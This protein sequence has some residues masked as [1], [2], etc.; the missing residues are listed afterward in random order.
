MSDAYSDIMLNILNKHQ[1]DNKWDGSLYEKIKRISNTKVGTIGQDFIENLC[2][3][4]Q[5]ECIFPED[6]KNHKR[7]NQS[8]WDIQIEGIKFELKTATEDT[9][10][11]FQF[12]HIRYHRI[13]DG[14]ICL[15]I[16]PNSIFYGIWSKAEVA[17]ND[18]G[19]LVSMEKNANASYKLTKQPRNLKP[20]SNFI[21]DINLLKSDNR[22]LKA[23]S[24]NL[25]S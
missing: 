1:D 24:K 18:C 2:G 9:N 10:G 7:L 19:N 8:P 11:N 12:N 4:F 15:G 5:I 14:L 13:Y 3:M 25:Q 21:Q 17:T 22:F 20:I 16:S 6:L 23:I